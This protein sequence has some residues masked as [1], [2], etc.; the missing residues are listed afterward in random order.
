MRLLENS[1][2]KLFLQPGL[3]ETARVAR[4]HGR[5]NNHEAVEGYR[6]LEDLA[7]KEHSLSLGEGALDRQG[8]GGSWRR[9]GLSGAER[10]KLDATI[11][12]A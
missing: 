9:L 12:R 3:P 7:E 5:P 11:A 10:R 4:F 1:T 2:G 8:R 6:N